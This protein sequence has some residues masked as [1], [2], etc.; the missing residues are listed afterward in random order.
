MGHFAPELGTLDS[1]DLGFNRPWDSITLRRF[2]RQ[3]PAEIQVLHDAGDR[4]LRWVEP[5]DIDDPTDYLVDDE[6]ILTSGY[7]LVPHAADQEWV[8]RF[9]QRLAQAKVCALGFG[10]EPYFSQVP[11]SLVAACLSHNVTLLQIPKSVPFAAIG[12]AF[13][14][15]MEADGAALLRTNAESNRALMRCVTQS[16]PEEQLVSTL[17][18]RARCSIKLLDSTGQVRFNTPGPVALQL[19]EQHEADL[20]AQA[21]LGE[22]SSQFAL[23]REGN[24][25]HLAFP[26][27]ASAAKGQAPLLGVL[28][29]SFPKDPSG[30]D[31]TLM[32]TTLGLLEVVARERAMVSFTSAQLATSLLTGAPQML[33]QEQLRLLNQGLGPH[34]RKP[35]RALVLAPSRKSVAADDSRH[36]AHL[37][38]LLETELVSRDD[39]VFIALSKIEPSEAQYRRLSKAGYLAAFSRPAILNPGLTEEPGQLL[40]Q[41]K[42]LIP[43][44]LEKQRS[45]DAAKLPRTFQTLLPKDAGRELAQQTLGGVLELP[46]K[47]RDLYLEVLRCWLD[48]NGSWDETSKRLDLHRNSVRRHI[49]SIAQFLDVD[50][51]SAQVR[52]ELFFA[53]RFLS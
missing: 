11:E 1:S 22:G 18:Q 24:T 12:L 23:L 48:S 46:A 25:T 52:N 20:Y 14:Q 21:S 27:R 53:L 39:G 26:I 32:A 7:P 40:A 30:F 50:L 5:S 45:M 41:A 9:V 44:V 3:L 16:N 4:P 6:L 51:G 34:H 49:T 36:L 2:L 47:R 19:S 33:D 42:G 8:D 43:Q 35:L 29:A 15:L 37:R 31:H 10:L 38:I 13:A 28:Q 17:A